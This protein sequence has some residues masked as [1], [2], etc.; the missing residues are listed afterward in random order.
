LT[1]ELRFRGEH[2][3][4]TED[5]GR[6]DTMCWIAV[7]QRQIVRTLVVLVA[8]QALSVALWEVPVV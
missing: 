6:E 4:A 7:A 1:L 2:R 8:L 3:K 5:P